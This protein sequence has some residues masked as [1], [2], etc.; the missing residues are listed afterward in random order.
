MKYQCEKSEL[1]AFTAIVRSHDEDDV[2][3]AHDDYQR[4]HDKRQHSEDIG[5]AWIEAVLELEA[6]LDCVER[7]RS[8]VA[9]NDA[10]CEKRQPGETVTARIGVGDRADL[11]FLFVVG[12]YGI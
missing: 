10:C 3:D 6:L 12:T 4:P 5:F 7:T 1:S 2:L 11:V 9:V 8:D